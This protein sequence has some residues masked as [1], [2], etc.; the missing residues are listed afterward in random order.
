MELFEEK[1]KSLSEKYSKV[2]IKDLI[3]FGHVCGKDCKFIR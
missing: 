2:E 1:I 3:V